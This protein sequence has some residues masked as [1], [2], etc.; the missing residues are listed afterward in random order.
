MCLCDT[1][2]NY[3]C[4]ECE[5]FYKDQVMQLI[6]HHKNDILEEKDWWW[7]INDYDINIFCY[8]DDPDSPDAI[9]SINLYRLDRDTTSSYTSDVQWDLEPMTRR[10]IRLA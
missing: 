6:H 4:F 2:E 1:N 3:L 8:E 7:T 10:E 5:C 9:F